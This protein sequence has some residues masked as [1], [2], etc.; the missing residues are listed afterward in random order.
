MPLLLVRN[1]LPDSEETHP[2]TP[3]GEEPA[4]YLG[5][6][7]PLL[8]DDRVTQIPVR[9]IRRNPMQPRKVF[10]DES[11]ATLADSI[12]RYGI[13]QPLTVRLLSPFRH[14]KE[15]YELVAGERRLRAAQSLGLSHVPCIIVEVD[16]RSSAELAIIENLQR[17]DLNIFEQAAAIS[18]LIHT[19]DVTQ[20]EIAARLSVSQSY[21]ANKLRLLRF[22]ETEQERILGAH[23]TERHA[24]A[25]LRISDDSLRVATM[26]TIIGRAMN[27]AAAEH[28]V[29]TVIARARSGEAGNRSGAGPRN[30]RY[31]YRSMDRAVEMVRRMGVG[32]SSVRNEN[33]REI[34]LIIRI[35][36]P[37]ADSADRT[38][39]QTPAPEKPGDSAQS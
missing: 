22:T 21:I 23:L 29:D 5:E 36:K 31:F 32:I 6:G 1:Q 15:G 11:I 39:A 7:G 26:E 4:E 24:R 38:A 35:A 9:S 14:V 12:Q 2:A 16:D 18:T 25:L 37:A 30:I 34:E 3:T 10:S 28:Y 8:R 17:E 13:L 20:E 27:V 33:D 19:Y